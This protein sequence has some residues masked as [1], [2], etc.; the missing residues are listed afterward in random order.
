MQRFFDEINQSL[1]KSISQKDL[2]PISNILN[3]TKGENKDKIDLLLFSAL[4]KPITSE[5]LKLILEFGVNINSRNSQIPLH[6]ALENKKS[7][8]II[9]LL[10]EYESDLF[11]TDNE[12]PLH[13][14]CKSCVDFDI[15]KLLVDSGSDIHAI[16]NE[17]PIHLA[18]C[19]NPNNDTIL[20][21]IEKGANIHL[22][23]ENLPFH[24]AVQ[25]GASLKVIEFLYNNLQE[26]LTEE[27]IDKLFLLNCQKYPSGDSLEFLLKLGA[28]YDNS[29]SK[30]PIQYLCMNNR[31]LE[32]IKVLIKW[33]FSVNSDNSSEPPLFLAFRNINCLETLNLLIDSGANI[34]TES[35]NVLDIAC[36]MKSSFPI[37]RRLI[38][39]G[40]KEPKRNN[41]K[42]FIL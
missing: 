8:S 36:Q 22:K 21:L 40:A 23:D 20:F 33:G 4:Q 2:K 39:S 38:L 12:T 10:I 7:L 25:N 41:V 5:I 37:F 15:I 11:I 1:D 27:E 26:K 32:A 35:K 30:T 16:T 3:R 19:P 29:Q 6:V 24:Y 13:T 42:F 31:S 9:K 17:E 14:A 18:C 34:E 28:K